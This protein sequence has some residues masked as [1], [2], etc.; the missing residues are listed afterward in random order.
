MTRHEP[1]P[2]QPIAAVLAWIWPGLGHVSLGHHRRGRLVMFGVLLLFLLGLLIGG[3]DSVDRRDDFLWFIAQ[4]FNGPIAFLADFFNQAWIKQMTGERAMHA[5]SIGR[6][7]EMGTLFC[8]LAGLMNLFA[9]LDALGSE[10]ASVETRAAKTTT[11][12]PQRR[13]TDSQHSPMSKQP[14]SREASS[15]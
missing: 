15:A 12:A 14:N 10:P 13:V 4:A 7:N 3:L 1:A 8:A 11:K 9:I 5:R 6:V 2:F